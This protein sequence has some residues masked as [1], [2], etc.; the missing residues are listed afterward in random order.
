MCI[1]CFN[2]E[3]KIILNIFIVFLFITMCVL[4][5]GSIVLQC[6]C[7]QRTTLWVWFSSSAFTWVQELKLRFLGSIC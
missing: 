1:Y 4:C 5:G 3:H 7:G 6:T 2:I